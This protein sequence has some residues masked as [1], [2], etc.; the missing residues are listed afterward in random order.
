VTSWV[1]PGFVLVEDAPSSAAAAIAASIGPAGSSAGATGPLIIGIGG[2]VAAGKSHCASSLAALLSGARA[3]VISTDGF[4]F[5][6]AELEAR[7]LFAR[8][9]FPESY[10]HALASD[11]LARLASGAEMVE[12][13]CYSH[14]TY[15][16]DGPP[17]VVH[18]PDVVIIEGVMALQPPIAE[19][20]SLRAYLDA[21]E[22]DL[23]GWYVSRFLTLVEE[24]EGFYAQWAGMGADDVSRLA[25]AVWEHVNLP[26]LVDRILPTRP[27]ADVIVRKGADHSVAAV[28]VRAQGDAR[29][30][31]GAHAD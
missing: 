2:G 10:D 26:N 11:V 13:P 19:F 7:G 14:Q 27:T 15:D 9:G 23:R 21:D 18:R 1:P 16:V 12:V 29:S 4:L 8:K 30:R 31:L 28:A 22:A 5:S 20:C 3:E 24:G 6:N 17:Q 25:T